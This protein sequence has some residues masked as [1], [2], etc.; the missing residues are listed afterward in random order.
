MMCDSRGQSP[1]LGPSL[2]LKKQLPVKCKQNIYCRDTLV[3][4]FIII[5]QPHHIRD[6]CN[7]SQIQPLNFALKVHQ[8]DQFYFKMYKIFFRGRNPRT[9][10]EGPRLIPQPAIFPIWL[11]AQK[12]G[13]PPDIHTYRAIWLRLSYFCLICCLVLYMG[14]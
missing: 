6:V 2:N 7:S 14:D 10:L 3:F 11:A 1:A 8:I 4:L 13:E 5:A 12:C 9:P